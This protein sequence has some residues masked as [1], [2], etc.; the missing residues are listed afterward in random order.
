MHPRLMELVYKT[1]MHFPGRR[2][3]IISGY[4][5][6]SVAKNPRSPHKEGRA[7][8]FRIEGIPNKVLRDFLLGTFQRVGVG[9]YR[10]RR[11]CT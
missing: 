11:S 6:P 10:T 9:Y 1:A 3:E 7:T 4:R 8:D 2:L 5:D